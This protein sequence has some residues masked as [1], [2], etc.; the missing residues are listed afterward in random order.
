VKKLLAI[1]TFCSLVAAALPVACQTFE[2]N[3]GQSSQAPSSSKGKSKK[4]AAASEGIGWGSSIEVGRLSRAAE[5]AL[6]KGNAN[7]AADFASRAVKAA[8][9][10][11]RLWFL[12]GYTSRLA[13]RE[14]E[15][16]SAYQRGLQLDPKSIEGLSGLAQTYMRMGRA[17]DAKSILLQVLAA[18]PRRP[19]D[20]MMAGELFLQSGDVQK[21]TD[22]LQ[23]SE[24]LNPNAHT[25][26]MLATAYMKSNQPDKA[27]QLLDRAKAHSKNADV[28]RAVANYY[29]ETKDYKSAIA[30]LQQIPMKT[31]DLLG[32][33]GYTYSLAGDSKQASQIYVKA[34]NEAPQDLNLQV[35]AAQSLVRTGD[36]E[37]AQKYL[38]RAAAI[39]PDSYRLHAI[40]ADIARS[41]RKTDEA[42]K[43][44]NLAIQN[45]PQG[46]VPEGLLYPIQLRMNLSEQYRDA[47]NEAGARQQLA[48]AQQMVNA[49]NVQGE[50]KADFL[51]LRASIR[52]GSGDFAGAEADLKAAR[53]ADPKNINVLIQ[54]AALLWRLKRNDEA[55]SLYT[56]ALRNDPKN[57]FALVSLGYL[58]RD[59]G[60]NKTAEEFFNKLAAAYRGDY[61]PY[62]ALGDLK[63]A[64]KDYAEAQRD[65][66]K[67][68][69]LAPGVPL[70]VGGGANA[71]IE[72]HNLPVA[73]AWLARAKG[74][75]NDDP[76][77]MK[78]R[79]RY[80][81]HTGKYQE[82]AD[83]GVKVVQQLPNDR[84]ASVYLAY[85]L[86]NLGRYDD[87][88]KLVREKEAVLPREANLPLLAGHVQKQM[89]LLSLAVQDYSH[90]IELD[91]RM[92]EAY[93][94]RGYVENDL[95]NAHAAK[96]D[97]DYVLKLAP[98]NGVAHLGLS[99][100]YLELHKGKLALDEVDLAS[101]TL[102]ESGSTHLARATAYRQQRLLA[103]A[104]KEY[105]AALKFAPKDLTL[106]LALADTLYHEH[107]YAESVTAL[108][109][110]LSLSPDDS[111]IFAELAHAHAQ[112][113][114]REQTLQYVKAAE[115]AGQD[116]SA[117]YLATGEALMT[118]GD[119]PAAMQR[120]VRALNAP[121]AN[122][123]DARLSVA[124]LFSR[125][126][127]WNDARQQIS[128]AFAESRVGEATPVTAD[129]LIEAANLFLAMHDFDLAERFFERAHDAGAA[130][131][132]VAI[133][134][135]NTYLARGEN[136]NA[137][138]E[139]ASLGNPAQFAADYD[140]TLALANVYRQRRDTRALSLF[141]RA[142]QLGGDNNIAEDDMQQL[143]AEQGWRINDRFNLLGEVAVTPIYEDNTIYQLDARLLGLAN[144]STVLPTPRDSIETRATT[145]Y[146]VHEN[147]LP[148]ISGYFQV[149]NARGQISL[150][151]ELL[152]VNRDTYDYSWNGALNPVLHLGGKNFLA[153]N[154]GLQA[155]IRRDRESPVQMNQNLF[156]QFVYMTS[157]SFFNWLSVRGSFLHESGPFT[158][159]DLSSRDLYG[160]IEFT[161]GRPW[162]KTAL[163]TGYT[164]R[165]LQYT[166][167][168]PY[169][170]WYSTSAYF[171]LQ[172]QFGENLKL[173]GIGEY[174]RAWRVQGNQ[175]AL[176]QAMRPGLQFQYTPKKNW[177][178]D[179]TFAY[180]RGEGFHA[181]DNV[182]SGV[183][184]S[185]VRSL[186]QTLDGGASGEVP[187]EYPI[188]FS[189]GF[190]QENF[191]NFTGR[192][193]TMFLPV[194]RLTLF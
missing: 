84:D 122:R 189:F 36:P 71:A 193:Q 182:Q 6:A 116:A 107:K 78:E 90:A 31:P 172:H 131:Q 111:F 154:T 145:G 14:A 21:G 83:L 133:G 163:L 143:A 92:I 82:S 59:N 174:I 19:T 11:A 45:L 137:E 171:G 187:V 109:N 129:N 148:E 147:G 139:L 85:D 166:G 8:P 1:V 40:R 118:L 44:Y 60:D 157:N 58:A 30:T 180:S 20:L 164:G 158:L 149:R 47:G 54:Y 194:I 108:N 43:E 66:E 41:A 114:H 25:E 169:R 61:V 94:N 188:R 70:I 120:F 24:S 127:K 53:A 162:G 80:L 3:G 2:I 176:A 121:D 15:S 123:L 102:G 81:F 134:L 42:I 190:Q 153:F 112:L 99:F 37:T 27:K 159:Q 173:A 93:L 192:N 103:D 5:N 56:E 152:I 38:A 113:H 4:G 16:L 146:R 161:V 35:S 184:I 105:L 29:R 141:A 144:N 87:V 34:A 119:N 132:V 104:E 52:S 13:G 33:I 125:E 63:T 95:Q 57:Q 168:P 110:A 151:S 23:R 89:Q 69:A 74:T 97:F 79:E 156:R 167:M 51:R 186:R 96:Q 136:R 72:A 178:V 100:S 185:Y 12:L 124:N 39:N 77:I 106:H 76:R 98:N 165:D 17:A 26:V 68:Y 170:E 65:Y 155:T 75:M 48:V 126:G 130:D 135:A 50:A 88:L 183:F 138:A 32:E 140:Y 22:L 55:S 10:E 115:A 117:I 7:A 62:L 49:L 142:N 91:P 67:A 64:T 179:G 177:L 175:F 9:Q 18:N 128:L 73:A 101:K 181:Y 46:G 28:F 150:P 86:Y 160:H 191:F